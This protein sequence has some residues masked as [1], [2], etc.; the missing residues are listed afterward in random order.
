MLVQ[1]S[2]LSKIYGK[3]IGIENL[4]ISLQSGETI[5]L[6][7]LNGSGKTT[8]L[9]L[10]AGLLHPTH[11]T[12]MLEGKTPW[13]QRH[14]LVFHSE[15]DTLYPW[16]DYNGAIKF[17]S[18]LY[19]NFNQKKFTELF[20][21]L[22]VPKSICAKMSK[23]QKSRFKLAISLSQGAKLILLDEPLSGI[24]IISRK[25]IMQTLLNEHGSDTTML[26]STHEIELAQE[27]FDR[28]LI[29]NNGKLV[30]DG[31]SEELLKDGKNIV[32]IFEE[33]IQ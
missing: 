7:G 4:S 29:V 16:L 3:K 2:Q 13:Q 11:G 12:I 5:G 21:L 33:A 32:S 10:L 24:D 17:M 8:T 18:G 31:S 26:I 19:P 22:E 30:L 14:Q 1:L 28:I 25:K 6:I 20:T 15:L 23:G 9:K 27:V